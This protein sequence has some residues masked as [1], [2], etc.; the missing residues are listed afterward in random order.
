[1]TAT[2]SAPEAV[3]EALRLVQA[4]ETALAAA[5]E[6]VRAARAAVHGLPRPGAARHPWLEVA[7]AS[8][9]N[10]AFAAA[11]AARKLRRGRRALAWAAEHAG[12]DTPWRRIPKT[13]RKERRPYR[14][15]D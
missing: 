7:R 15:E 6:A 14:S 10:G 9:H 11:A 12:T 5:A 8:T 2:P 13:T 4:A 1:M 3:A